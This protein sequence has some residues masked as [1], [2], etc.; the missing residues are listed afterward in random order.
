MKSGPVS[1]AM[2]EEISGIA[3]AAVARIADE[4]IVEDKGASRFDPVSNVDREVERAIAGFLLE[5]FPDDEV[6]GEEFGQHAAGSSR[7]WSIDPIDGTRS[8]I[9]GLPSWSILVGLVANGIHVAGMIDLPALSQLFIAVDGATTCNGAVVQT[10][11][12]ETLDKARLSTTDP[13][14]FETGEFDAFDRLRKRVS[15]ARYG[16]DGA[17]YARLT[18]GGLDLVVESGLKPHDYDAIIPVVRFAG[19]HVGDW[20]GGKDFESGRI[21]AAATETLY[22][23]AVAIMSA[24]L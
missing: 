15:F 19:G 10:S 18:A 14:L 1:V 7:R 21:I 11:G 24:A 4:I 3:R 9:C 22:R 20:S 16:L 13:F 23:R 17:A 5:R 6:C 2:I 12:C 8:F